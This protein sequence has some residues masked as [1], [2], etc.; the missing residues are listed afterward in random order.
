V[1]IESNDRAAQTCAGTSD[2]NTYCWGIV[3]PFSGDLAGTSVPT[4]VTGSSRFV[5]L[6]NR[7]RPCG[8]TSPGA[9]YCWGGWPYD[10]NPAVSLPSFAVRDFTQGAGHSCASDAGGTYYC[11]DTRGYSGATSFIDAG[12]LIFS[13]TP[14]IVAGQQ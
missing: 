9:V 13:N 10:P 2:F 12:A 4:L 7:A 6:H 3:V 1:Q 8:V 5:R 11:W 14:R